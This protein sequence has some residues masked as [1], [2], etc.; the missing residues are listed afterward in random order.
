MKRCSWCNLNNPLYIRYHDEEWGQPN[1]DERYLLEM[2]ILESFQAGLSWECVLNKREAFRQAYDQF[3]LNKICSYDE[4]KLQELAQNKGIIRNRLK[5]KASVENA[6]IFKAIQKEY[7]SF[8]NYLKI[9]TQGKT[10]YEVGLT[11]SKLSDCLSA[12]LKKKGMKFVGTTII[13]S[14]L[15]AIGIIYSHDENCDLYHAT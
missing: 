2:L 13:Y 6:K 11:S 8:Y 5:I 10:F 7:G 15:Q 1:F 4:T 3:D 14:Y 9:F 12:D